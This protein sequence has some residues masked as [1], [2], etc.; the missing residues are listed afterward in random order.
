M[1][2]FNDDEL[3]KGFRRVIEGKSIEPPASL[4]AD[5]RISALERQLIRYRSLTLWFK[6]ATGVLTALLGGAVYF[7]CQ[8]PKPAPPLPK[9]VSIVTKMDTVYVTRTEK[10]YIDRPVIV[11]TEK[12]NYLIESPGANS[13][14]RRFGANHLVND[15]KHI[16]NEAETGEKMPVNLATGSALST[17]KQNESATSL[18]GNTANM[19]FLSRK[20]GELDNGTVKSNQSTQENAISPGES[21]TI[22]FL[23]PLPIQVT[24]SF[25]PKINV[26]PLVKTTANWFKTKKTFVGKLSLSGY[27]T[28]KWNSID[29]RRG[30]PNAFKYGNEKLEPG[31]AVGVRAGVK[32]SKRWSL[33]AGI[34]VEGTRFG[35]GNH[36]QILTAEPINGTYGYL[37]RTALGTVELP[38]EDFSVQAQAGSVVGLEIHE[39]IQRYVLNLPLS[40][41]YDV[42]SK[43]F[44]FLQQLPMKLQFYGLLG[45]YWQLPLLQEGSVD[46]FENTGRQLTGELPKFHNL[47]SSFGVNVGLGTELGIGKRFHLFVEPTYTQGI[48]SVVR[49]MPLRSVTNSFGIKV[50]TKW[51]FKKQ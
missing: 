35:D 43:R 27:L 6:G 29:V 5:I 46:I 25:T 8:V 39:Y 48:S 7:I 47:H 50:G 36:R 23:E 1:A 16:K 20:R 11:Y 12:S 18:I 38:D 3:D 44:R 2:D 33:L 37:Y 19:A 42:W 15:S 9:E 49:D 28:P 17:W 26:N 13:E 4:W 24:S 30:E 34:E 51:S 40:I 32:I 21:G 45:W 31:A 41:R 14:N 10:V 22:D